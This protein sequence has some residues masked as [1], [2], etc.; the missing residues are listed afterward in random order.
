[1]RDAMQTHFLTQIH[2]VEHEPLANESRIQ[3]R[4]IDVREAAQYLGRTE[5]SIRHL[6][7]RRKIR[8]IRADGRV[9]FDLVDLNDWIDMNRS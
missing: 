4:I 9:M 7:R 8:C 6:V 3:R 2:P 5:K 1:M